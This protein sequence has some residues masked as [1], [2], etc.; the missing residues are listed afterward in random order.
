MNTI[1]DLLPNTPPPLLL[2]AQGPLAIPDPAP[3][4]ASPFLSRMLLESPW[5]V[6]LLLAI[7]AG[8]CWI[9]LS[10]RGNSARAR[11]SCGLLL[12]LAV[13]VLVL[14]SAIT[15]GRE[16]VREAAKQL[17]R[18]VAAADVPALR[19]ALAFE[20]VLRLASNGPELDASEIL[21]RVERDFS[22][23]GPFK[24]KEYGILETQSAVYD[25]GLASA[26]IKVRVTAES[27]GLLLSWWRVDFRPEGG[28]WRV[29]SIRML[30]NS[31]TGVGGLP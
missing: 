27:G 8:L 25:D 16:A 10:N 20:C 9:V 3:L 15:T 17:V 5:P 24:V 6:V 13:G 4:P 12:A 26:Q 7:A 14:A 2:L 11:G 31:A 23:R 1:P 28:R 22:D 29:V 21:D 19:S 30:S 18:D